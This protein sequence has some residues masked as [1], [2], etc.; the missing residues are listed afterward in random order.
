MGP[1]RV[2]VA[3]KNANVR[4][5]WTIRGRQIRPL[6]KKEFPPLPAQRGEMIV[7]PLSAATVDVKL[8][9][10]K[11]STARAVT[12]SDGSFRVE[13]L[14]S[15]RYSIRIRALGYTPRPL[16]PIELRLPSSNYDVGTVVLNAAPVQLQSL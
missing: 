8:A 15:G 12:A 2:T 4:A 11:A 6:V 13:G 1:D 14:Q 9:G 5:G 3:H 7:A 16:A 10:A